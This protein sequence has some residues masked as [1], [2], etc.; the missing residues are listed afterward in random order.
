MEAWVHA[1]C[2]L[3]S[4]RQATWAFV[5][6]LLLRVI[7]ASVHGPMAVRLLLCD[8]G[9]RDGSVAAPADAQRP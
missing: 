9:V 7:Q 4:S 3:P 6:E 1:K 8:L 2:R 5:P